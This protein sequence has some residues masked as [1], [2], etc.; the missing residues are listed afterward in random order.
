MAYSHHRQ[1]YTTPF[2]DFCVQLND[3]AAS[4]LAR[5][6]A[7]WNRVH[8][9]AHALNQLI[10]A[11]NRVQSDHGVNGP[12]TPWNE[13]MLAPRSHHSARSSSPYTPPR[14][15]N[16][17]SSSV[18]LER[19]L[20]DLRRRLQECNAQ[21]AAQVE[22]LASQ[23]ETLA[24]T[25]K[26]VQEQQSIITD[27]NST[28]KSL[29][30]RLADQY[31]A[32]GRNSLAADQYDKLQAML[33]KDVKNRR[34]YQDS[35]GA[36]AAEAKQL[37]FQI[38]RA[39]ALLKEGRVEDAESSVRQVL[40]R[41]KELF[42]DPHV[43]EPETREA[44]MLLCDILRN[45]NRPDK[46]HEAE[47]MYLRSAPLVSMDT[48]ADTDRE[49]QLSNTL[50]LSGSYVEQKSYRAAVAKVQD[51]WHYRHLISRTYRSTMTEEILD[52]VDECEQVNEPSYAAKLFEIVYPDRSNAIAATFSSKALSTLARLALSLWNSGRDDE[53]A[54]ALTRQAYSARSKLDTNWQRTLGWT[55]AKMRERQAQW[56]DVCEIL[57]DL[58]PRQ[59]ASSTT[60]VGPK[61][62][63]DDGVLALLAYAQLQLGD[64]A[65]AEKNA[66]ALWRKHGATNL[67]LGFKWHHADTLIR[68]LA[69]QDSEKKSSS[70]RQPSPNGGKT[71]RFEEAREYWKKLLDASEALMDQDF[72]RG[73]ATVSSK[74]KDQWRREV[75]RHAEAGH[76]LASMW[77][78]SCLRRA[79]RAKSA[80]EIKAEA[81]RLSRA[82]AS[83]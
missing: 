53:K 82:V 6:L 46:V 60:S 5:N 83:R 77:E 69:S 15:P 49:W 44:Q 65:G 59:N 12:L 4:D 58:P 39:K 64:L 13:P 41:R 55:L 17:D 34:S 54:T 74:D 56:T 75:R 62:P 10:S 36:K 50:A 48:L 67:S 23:R 30:Q 61:Q 25:H 70:S 24:T 31:T 28:V 27:T 29:R 22:E 76:A 66:L 14:T 20:D 32:A 42:S 16:S 9:I 45:S 80:L 51:A 43:K 68:A 19:K 3:L 35:T 40:Q 57:L 79:I 47:G 38:A 7:K 11:T 18:Q 78:A 52:L 26:T 81:D 71:H 63:S 2:A 8:D 72:L 37:Q 1:S 21:I 33:D 73:S